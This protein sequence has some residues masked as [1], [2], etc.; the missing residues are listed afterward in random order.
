MTI[1]M[2]TIKYT[3]VYVAL[4]LFIYAAF[5]PIVVAQLS[6]PTVSCGLWIIWLCFSVACGAFLVP[7]H[8][9]S[10]EMQ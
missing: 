2:L 6:M 7:R 9:H 3:A 1:C 4:A 5:L 10:F 8:L